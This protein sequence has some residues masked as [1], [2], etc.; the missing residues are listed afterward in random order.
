MQYITAIIAFFKAIPAF[1]DLI[2]QLAVWWIEL[3]IK[4][5]KKELQDAIYKASRGDQQDLEKFIG[6]EHAGEPSGEPGSRIVDKL[7][8]VSDTVKR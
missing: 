4:T 1:K 3:Q 6:S 7:P 2:D 5:M 8:G